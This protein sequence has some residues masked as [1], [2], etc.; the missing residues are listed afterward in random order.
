[1]KEFDFRKY[2]KHNPLMEDMRDLAKRPQSLLTKHR[3]EAEDEFWQRVTDDA[4][5]QFPDYAEEIESITFGDPD[6]AMKRYEIERDVDGA[7]SW[8]LDSLELGEPGGGMYEGEEDDQHKS[9]EI[10]EADSM[11]FDKGWEYDDDDFGSDDL[12]DFNPQ[13]ERERFLG[14]GGQEILDGIKFLIDDGFEL[15]DIIKQIK[16]HSNYLQGTT[17]N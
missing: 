1:M 8:V 2:L 4:T 14:L 6:R 5:A 17:I 7:V 3:P 9:D 12:D 11:I 16:Q 13:D 10:N 15:E